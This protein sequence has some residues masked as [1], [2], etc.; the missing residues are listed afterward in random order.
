MN[1]LC[2]LFLLLANAHRKNVFV[3]QGEGLLSRRFYLTYR[4]R[5]SVDQ[6]IN[7]GKKGVHKPII[8]YREITLFTSSSFDVRL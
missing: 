1:D 4:V 7:E 2:S 6:R 8:R 3:L 5:R